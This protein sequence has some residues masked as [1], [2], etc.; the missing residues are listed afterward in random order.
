MARQYSP[1]NFL[2]QTSNALLDRYFHER[3]LLTALEIADLPET[4][5]QPM[6][7]A[8]MALS[9]ERSA[10][11][12]SNFALVDLLAD[13]QGIQAIIDEAGFHDLDL[14]PAFDELPGF[15][16][17]AL[18]ALLDHRG[19]VEVAARFREADRLPNSYWVRRRVDVP[20]GDPRDDEEAC[21]ELAHELASYFRLKEGRGRECQVDVYRRS[22]AFYY[23]GFP[24]DYGRAELE[25]NEGKLERRAQRPVF[26]VVFVFDPQQ[27]ALDT[28]FR[29]PKK[30]RLELEAI[31]GRVILGAEL[32]SAKDERVYNLNAFKQRDVKFVY[33][34]ASGI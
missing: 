22:G 11:V 33:D 10:E 4:M 17:K 7:D 26:Q 25:Y 24:E 29:G 2:R 16:D 15:Q 28:F 13:E 14:V 32:T 34:P 9:S 5:I 31:F 30:P 20:T 23:F 21:A 19:I 27:R 1:R 3:G 8:W 12:D 6:F 18:L